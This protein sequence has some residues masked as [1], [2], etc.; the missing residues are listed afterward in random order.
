MIARLVAAYNA[1]GRMGAIAAF[2]ELRPVQVST[3]INRYCTVDPNMVP[4][5][6]HS[7]TRKATVWNDPQFCRRFHEA[8]TNRTCTPYRK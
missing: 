6:G 8:L 3:A 4:V 1:S 2:P 7:A 5:T